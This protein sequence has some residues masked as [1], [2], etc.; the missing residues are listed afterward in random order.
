[1]IKIKNRNMSI[2]AAKFHLKEIR[3]KPLSQQERINKA[4]E[5]ASI[6]LKISRNSRLRVEK[7]R[8]KWLGKMMNDPKGRLFATQMADLCFRSQNPVRVIDQLLYLIEEYGVPHFLSD[9]ERI[10]FL[11]FQHFGKRYPAFF[12]HR[13]KKKLKRELAAVLIPDKPKKFIERCRKSNIRINLNH[14]GEA[15]LGEDEAERRLQTYLDDLADPLID[16]ISVKCSGLYSQINLIAF[17]QTLDHLADK[18]R[19]LY[20]ASSPHQFVNLD[21]EEY[22]DLDLTVALFKKV[23]DEPEFLDRHAGIVL[24]SYLPESFEV[25]QE[26]TDWAVKRG[27]AP[28]K[29]RLVK[30]ANLGMEAVESSMHNWRQ[31]P[32]ERKHESDANFKR[33]LNYALDPKHIHAV[34][35]GVGSHNLLDIAYALVLRSET[36]SEEFVDFEMLNGMATS[37]QR[38]IKQLTGSVVLYSPEAKFHHF[39][40]ALSY[41]IRR[42]DENGSPQNFLRHAFQFKPRNFLWEQ[43]IK[44]FRLACRKMDTLTSERRRMVRPVVSNE[45]DSD[46]ALPAMRAKVKQ[47]YQPKKYPDIPLVIGGKELEGER[48]SGYDPST[49]QTLYHYHV[50]DQGQVEEAL[51]SCELHCPQNVFKKVAENLRNMREEL[52][53]AMLADGG[54]IPTESDPEISEAIDFVEYYRKQ[55]ANEGN[56]KGIIL[57]ASPWNFPVAIPVGGIAAALITGNAVLFKPAPEAILTG[58]KLAQAF[59]NAGVPK[60]T[61]QFL[62]C[63]DEPVGSA[64]IQNPKIASVILTGATQTARHFLKLRPSLDLMAETGGKNSLIVSSMADR[65]LA[66]RDLVH[67]A[68]GHAGQKCSACSLGIL[69]K[70]DL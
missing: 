25:L 44:R 13:I 61:L 41:L 8:E 29:I 21:M 34:H 66:I 5:L 16:Y 63:D 18:L 65:D 64:L 20:R 42:L 9:K 67:S 15:I 26:L 38:T 17:D 28:I 70:R 48:R 55:W 3:G 56:P 27:G 22:R 58:W 54:K 2:K 4:V 12:L 33:M 23:L 39:Q 37:T 35:I 57:V 6:L 51:D 32:F 50:A 46:F 49:N 52:M 43:E 30:G 10:Q 40:N 31:A 60:T 7:K 59:W 11:L 62:P 36:E 45:P 69:E 24:Q 53:A 1:M 47:I 19:Q 68:F 14:L